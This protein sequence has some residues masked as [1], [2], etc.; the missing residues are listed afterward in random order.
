MFVNITQCLS[1]FFVIRRD[2][3]ARW[4]LETGFGC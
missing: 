3:S 2:Y 4:V 1:K